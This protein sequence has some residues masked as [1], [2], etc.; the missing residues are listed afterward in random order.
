MS[1][2]RLISAETQMGDTRD[3]ALRPLSFGDFVGQAAA[4]SNLKVYVEAARRRGESLDHLL[5]SGPPGL[6]LSLIHI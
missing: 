3:R 6:G 1:E 4:I 5:L 2:E